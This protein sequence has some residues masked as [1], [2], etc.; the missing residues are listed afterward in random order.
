MPSNVSVVC[1]RSIH[2]GCLSASILFFG[3]VSKLHRKFEHST[4]NC[5][6]FV[7]R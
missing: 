7:S 1:G 6:M 4:P 3:G 5:I 2:G